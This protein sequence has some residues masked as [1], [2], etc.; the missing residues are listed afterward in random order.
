M[1]A[2]RLVNSASVH[3]HSDSSRG[4]RH[5]EP[6]EVSKLEFGDN[7]IRI[8][9]A[10]SSTAINIS[11]EKVLCVKICTKRLISTFRFLPGEV[12]CHDPFPFKDILFWQLTNVGNLG[13]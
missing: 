2:C 3:E 9:L 11:V 8:Q 7:C 12:C 13:Y 10:S 4:W 5:S 1:V 6:Y